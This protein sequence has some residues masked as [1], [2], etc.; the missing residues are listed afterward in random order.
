MNNDKLPTAIKHT[1]PPKYTARCSYILF[2]QFMHVPSGPGMG[3]VSSIIA[4]EPLY[5][6]IYRGHHS[7]VSNR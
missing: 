7:T 5:A 2:C 3:R 1:F 4:E 6:I